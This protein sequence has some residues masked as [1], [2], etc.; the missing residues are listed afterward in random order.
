MSYHTV[1][2]C[3]PNAKV[4]EWD[5]NGTVF[6][7]NPSI[8]GHDAGHTVSTCSS[9]LML[10]GNVLFVVFNLI[11]AC[12]FLHSRRGVRPQRLLSGGHGSGTGDFNHDGEV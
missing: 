3:Q 10:C 4:R 11:S 7:F 2:S 9:W 8:P 1:K 6:G 12:Q 5:S